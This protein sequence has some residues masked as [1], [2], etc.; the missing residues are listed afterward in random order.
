M[1]RFRQFVCTL[2]PST[3]SRLSPLW[4]L[5][6][7]MLSTPFWRIYTTSLLSSRL[8]LQ[9]G[10]GSLTSSIGTLILQTWKGENTH[11]GKSIKWWNEKEHQHIAILNGERTMWRFTDKFSTNMLYFLV[12]EYLDMVLNGSTGLSNPKNHLLK[13]LWFYHHYEGGYGCFSDF[14]KLWRPSWKNS[15]L[16]Y[17]RCSDFDR[18]FFCWLVHPIEMKTTKKPFVAICSRLGCCLSYINPPIVLQ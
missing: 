11:W 4:T 7:S 2:N 12:K 15:V 10:H 16:A 17:F 3:T 6:A 14:E 13:K 8:P 18:L 9:I 5:A 1:Y